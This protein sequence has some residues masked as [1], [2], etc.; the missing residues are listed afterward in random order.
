MK[1]WF[2]V[3]FNIIISNIFPEDFIEIFQVNENLKFTVEIGGK[4]LRF[5]DL[6]ITID[7]KKLATSVYSKPTNSHLYLDSTSCH[8]AKS[9]DLTWSRKT[10]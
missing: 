7:D 6:K 5:L 3:A 8:P 10:T 2:F 1:S 4:L 9:I